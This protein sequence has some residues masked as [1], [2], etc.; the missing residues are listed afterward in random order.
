MTM[1]D[2]KNRNSPINTLTP[3]TEVCHSSPQCSA[4]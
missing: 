4:G 2:V 3:G 1:I